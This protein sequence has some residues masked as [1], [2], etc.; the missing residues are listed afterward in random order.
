MACSSRMQTFPRRPKMTSKST[1]KKAS[2][3]AKAKAPK[4]QV[5]IK[6][7]TNDNPDSDLAMGEDGLG[8]E[9]GAMTEV[10]P[11]AKINLDAPTGLKNFRHHPDME[12]F[13]RFLFEND[14]RQ[15]ALQIINEILL[16]KR[17]RKNLKLKMSSKM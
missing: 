9:E 17:A 7:A 8:F 1:P 3:K 16:E 5:E 13:Y 2:A 11:D 4:A 14:L 12:N 6:K 10:S 15:E